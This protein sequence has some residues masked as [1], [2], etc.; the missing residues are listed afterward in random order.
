MFPKPF[1]FVEYISKIDKLLDNGILPSMKYCQIRTV[2]NISLNDL[3]QFS[4]KLKL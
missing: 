3:A 1:S 2:T 4:I